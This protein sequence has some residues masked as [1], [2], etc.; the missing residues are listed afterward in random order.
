V[1]S[2]HL[3]RSPPNFFRT[4]R[5]YVVDTYCYAPLEPSYSTA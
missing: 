4:V 1:P 5:A 3:D 2:F